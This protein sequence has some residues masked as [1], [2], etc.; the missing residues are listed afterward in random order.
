MEYVGT[1]K[2]IASK[3][4][5]FGAYRKSSFYFNFDAKSGSLV[6]RSIFVSTPDN[7][8]EMTVVEYGDIEWV[9]LTRSIGKYL[10]LKHTLLNRLI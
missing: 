9:A 7:E 5:F 4:S 6:K 10:I 8:Y 1:E 3:L 2:N